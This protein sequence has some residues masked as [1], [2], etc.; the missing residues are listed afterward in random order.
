MLSLSMR[1]CR[2]FSTVLMLMPR[3]AAACLLACA[4]ATNPEKGTATSLLR[5]RKSRTQHP[6]HF[7]PAFA[8]PFQRPL[9]LFLRHGDE[10]RR[11]IAKSSRRAMFLHSRDKNPAIRR[12]TEPMRES[13][14]AV[15][16]LIRLRAEQRPGNQN[17]LAQHDHFL[18][19]LMRGLAV[20]ISARALRLPVHA[21]D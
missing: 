8:R 4:S 10:L 12:L 5:Y 21:L 16:E 1:C 11:R 7:L 14:Q 3:V 15:V 2:C 9:L 19:P 6:P 13:F 20:V 17:L 18:P